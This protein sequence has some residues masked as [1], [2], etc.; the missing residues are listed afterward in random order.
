MALRF[1]LLLFLVSGSFP[2]IAAADP[3]SVSLYPALE[4]AG[5]RA[6]HNPDGVASASR[7]R[8]PEADAAADRIEA[9]GKSLAAL[10]DRDHPERSLLLQKPTNRIAHTGG[11]RIVPGSPEEALLKDWIGRLAKMSRQEVARA[12][13]LVSAALRE[14]ARRQHGPVLRRLTN[15]Q[16][17]NTVRDLVGELGA[18]ASQFPPEDFVNGYK[19][20]YQAQSLSPMLFEAYS[21]AAEKIARNA[22]RRGDASRL[23][24]CTPSVACRSEFVRSFGLKAFRRPLDASEQKRYQA[25]FLGGVEFSRGAQAVIEAMLQSPH[26]LFQLD[27]TTDPAWKPYVRASRL[28]YALW[29]TMPDDALFASAAAGALNS[30]EGVERVA[31][32]MLADPKA[33]EALDEFVSQWMRFDR[34][35]GTGR[36]T[37]VYPR[38]NRE[39]AAAMTEETRRFVADLVWSDRNFMEVFT[40]PYGYINAELARIYELAAP[41]GEF[42][43]VPFAEA[44]ER[45]GLLGQASFLTLTSTPNDTSPTARGLFVREHFLC[46]HIPDPPPGVSTVLP[47]LDEAKPQTN[48]QRLAAH[49]TNATCASCH[50]LIDP[51]GFGL[52]KFDAIGGRREKAKLLFYP[53]DRK[54]KEPPRKVELDLDTKGHVAGIADSDFS[55]PRELGAILA[56]TPQCQECIVKQAFRYIAGRLETVADRPLIGKI[57]EDFRESGFRFQEMLVSMMVAREFPE[58]A[59]IRVSRR[60]QSR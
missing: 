40:A 6:C 36:D 51:I 11:Q 39:S 52:E 21:T 22:F 25:Y 18:P 9:F 8:F 16:Y 43:R 35:T 27:D 49:T 31:R 55:S 34:V 33:K 57:F 19:N 50:N 58:S 30:R 46:Q 60:E 59:A 15:T 53:L 28:S 44:A 5:C 10:V 54:S 1:V 56:R 45:A 38:F 23:I 24:P 47:P 29:N 2:V 41:Q 37:R 12:D 20:Q 13:E 26:F 7:L 42:E 17:N 32:R 3:F 4:A 14:S 48:R